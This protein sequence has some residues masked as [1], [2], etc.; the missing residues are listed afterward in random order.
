KRGAAGVAVRSAG[1]LLA[2][3][4]G[5]QVGI[6]G[7]QA[8]DLLEVR[9][10]QAATTGGYT[11]RRLLELESGGHGVTRTVQSPRD[12]PTGQ[13]VDLGQPTN[14]GPQ[15]DVHDGLLRLPA[16]ASRN[17]SPSTISPWPG[18]GRRWMP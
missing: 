15:G 17:S 11:C 9:R 2:D 12:D 1:D 16:S 3:T 10:E 7:E 4:H 6:L 18:S 14:L 13:L 5:R 8:L